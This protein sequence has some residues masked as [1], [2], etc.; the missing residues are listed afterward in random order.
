MKNF[1][2]ILLLTVS[3]LIVTVGVYI[4]KFPNNFSFGGVTGMAVVLGKVLP[5][6]PGMITFAINMLLIVIGF[7][8][9][10]KDF[11]IKTIYV[12]LLMSAG[13]WAMEYILPLKE[14]VTDEP[15]LELAF[16]VA[17]P[18]LG[19]AILFNIGASSGGTDI[20]AM[21]LRKNTSIDIG[22]ALFLSDIIITLTA[23]P[24]FGVKTGLLSFFGLMV[25]TLVID[26]VIESINLCKYFNVVCDNPEPICNFIVNNLNRSASV[27][28][29]QGAFSHK[30][31]YIILT[32]LKRSQAVQ[33]RMF[34]KQVEPG[35]FILISNT[36]EIIGRGFRN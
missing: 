26:G 18:A 23:F 2:E 20:V 3:T 27:I 19:Q 10:G 14:P 4:F 5:M 33:L 28:D 22:R 35:A 15:L 9:L 25:K 30:N 11:G 12:S 7:I 21:I 8:F 31:K 24:L 16:A 34:I 17:L 29:A 6:S 32:V 1:K 13:L 36:S